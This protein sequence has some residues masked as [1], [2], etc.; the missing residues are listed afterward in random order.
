M[1]TQGQPIEINIEWRISYIR[2]I[3]FTL[4][5]FQE[6]LRTNLNAYNSY[7]IWNISWTDSDSSPILQYNI[8]TAPLF[9]AVAGCDSHCSPVVGL[10]SVPFFR[11]SSP[12][13]PGWPTSALPHLPPTDSFPS[14][15][16]QPVTHLPSGWKVYV[17][18]SCSLQLRFSDTGR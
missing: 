5:L 10:Q 4:L 16:S 2:Y 11:L 9:L 6:S 7:L 14:Y 13:P 3:I 18:S 17:S 12:P 15:S 8:R 1:D